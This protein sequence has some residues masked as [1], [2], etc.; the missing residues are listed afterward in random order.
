MPYIIFDIDGTI[1]DNTHRQHYLTSKKKDWKNFFAEMDLD[2]P[3]QSII[4]L[5]QIIYRNH[6]RPQT[7]IILVTGRPERYRLVTMSWLTKYQIPW[8]QLWMRKDGDRREDWV[9]KEEILKTLIEHFDTLPIFVVDDRQQVV[10]MWRRHE[11]T[12]LQPCAPVEW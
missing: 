4:T 8:H 11:I 6:T 7:N 10:D 1:A 5:M 2:I 9:V 12:C 3:I